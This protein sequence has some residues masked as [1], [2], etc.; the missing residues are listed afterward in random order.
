MPTP[1]RRQRFESSIEITFRIEGEPPAQ[2]SALNRLLTA[3]R[4]ALNGAPAD[5]EL[6]ESLTPREREVA[7]LLA[8]G[9]SEADIADRLTIAAG[10]V[11][12]HRKRV[13]SKLHIHSR[14]EL[15]G[16]LGS[17]EEGEGAGGTPNDDKTYP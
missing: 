12:S 4:S 10:T 8:A 2:Q 6:G 3:L 7:A 17:G 5:A 1:P 13:Y 14:A 9:V 16:L 11:H 15:V